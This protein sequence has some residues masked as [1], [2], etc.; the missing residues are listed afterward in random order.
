MDLN[1]M[2]TVAASAALAPIGYHGLPGEMGDS[3]W[4]EHL[5]A[6]E[7]EETLRQ[8]RFKRKHCLRDAGNGTRSAC[9]NNPPLPASR[10]PLSASSFAFNERIKLYNI[11]DTWSQR[12]R[13]G[14]TTS[15]LASARFWASKQCV[16]NSAT[17]HPRLPGIGYIHVLNPG[18]SLRPRWPAPTPL[19]AGFGMPMC[20]FPAWENLLSIDSIPGPGSCPPARH[21][22][23][24]TIGLA[25]WA[26][27]APRGNTALFAPG[28]YAR[29]GATI[30]EAWNSGLCPAPESE[31]R[32]PGWAAAHHSLFADAL[33]PSHP[34]S[35]VPPLRHVAVEHIADAIKAAGAAELVG[36][37]GERYGLGDAGRGT[38]GA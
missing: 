20:T 22:A 1:F 12:S 10:C 6:F 18:R 17:E 30:V 35:R 23:R 29:L 4:L 11:R 28:A 26:L 21:A 38:R 25:S 9:R 37:L 3:T 8:V 24:D 36:Y 32:A 33:R 13:I 27:V 5:N 16:S 31:Q 34:A 14:A 7:R 19:P 2:L 15:A